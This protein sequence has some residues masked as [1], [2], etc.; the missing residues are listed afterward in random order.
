MTK[1]DSADDGLLLSDG[2]FSLASGSRVDTANTHGTGCTL[3]SAIACGLACDLDV[4]EAVVRAKTYVT[5]A[6]CRGLDLGRG[7][8]PPITCG[9]TLV[10]S[11]M[12]KAWLGNAA[13]AFDAV[14]PLP[15]RR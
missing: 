7:S 2:S 4:R 6:L 13:A 12:L 1:P 8:G 11:R 15:L 3:S 14:G 5:G 9:V 10:F